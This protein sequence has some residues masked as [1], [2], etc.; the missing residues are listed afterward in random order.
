MEEKEKKG[1]IVCSEENHVCQ[2]NTCILSVTEGVHQFLTVSVFSLF[3]HC[4]CML[5]WPI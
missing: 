4:V 1:E 3:A 5:G 2:L